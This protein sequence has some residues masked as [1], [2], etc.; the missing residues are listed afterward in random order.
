MAKKYLQ[1]GDPGLCYLTHVIADRL[2]VVEDEGSMTGGVS[3][4][5]SNLPD[6]LIVDGYDLSGKTVLHVSKDGTCRLL[7][8]D[9]VGRFIAW[10]S[11]RKPH[12]V[13]E[14]IVAVI[15]PEAYAAHRRAGALP[16]A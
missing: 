15:G 2:I 9:H 1:P 7:M 16:A 3:E 13:E 6:E 14:G 12:G 4:E 11:L 10:V 8:R 5:A